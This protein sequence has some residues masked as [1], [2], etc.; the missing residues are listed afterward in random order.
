MNSTENRQ[1]RNLIESLG[2]IYVGIQKPIFNGDDECVFFTRVN[3]ATVLSLPVSQ[4]TQSA[5]EEKLGKRAS[6]KFHLVEF[7]IKMKDLADQLHNLA[8]QIE[9]ELKNVD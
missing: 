8:N 6:P 4:C 2:G 7:R 3:S 1:L 9:E 5:I